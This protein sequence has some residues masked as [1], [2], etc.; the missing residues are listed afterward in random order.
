[1]IRPHALTLIAALPAALAACGGGPKPLPKPDGHV[2]RLNPDR[3][4]ETVNDLRQPP[5]RFAASAPAPGAAAPDE[6]APGRG[7]PR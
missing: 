7:A 3:W 6:D 2:F 5:R 1:M 4:G